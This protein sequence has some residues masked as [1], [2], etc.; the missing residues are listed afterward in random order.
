MPLNLFRSSLRY[1]FYTHGND[2]LL[3]S[4]INC[5]IFIFFPLFGTTY[6]SSLMLSLSQHFWD[7]SLLLNLKWANIFLKTMFF[8]VK[9]LICSLFSIK[10][11]MWVYEICKSLH[12]AFINMFAQRSFFTFWNWVYTWILPF[13]AEKTL[14]RVRWCPASCRTNPKM[15]SIANIL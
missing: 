3:I 6:F 5:K 1:P 7:V 12:S 4:L 10:N 2:H 15:T 11:K 13:R 9:D 8:Q 14:I